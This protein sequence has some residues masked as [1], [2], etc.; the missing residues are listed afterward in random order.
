MKTVTAVAD[1]FFRISVITVIDDHGSNLCICL[2]DRCKTFFLHF[3]LKFFIIFNDTIVDQRNFA[4]C[5]RV[6]ICIRHTTVGS[7]ACMSDTTVG[8]IFFC[9][10]IYFLF[11][12]GYFSYC[13]DGFDFIFIFFKIGDACAIIT[14][15]FQCLKPGDQH[16]FCIFYS[17]ITCN[18]T[19]NFLLIL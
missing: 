6:R 8:F 2:R 3:I 17:N 11:E 19:H 1:G 7:P 14:A 9:Q 18:S 12:T 5:M 10:F 15:V 13:F 16:F 4:G